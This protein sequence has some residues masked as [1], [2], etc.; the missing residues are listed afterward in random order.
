MKGGAFPECHLIQNL[1]IKFFVLNNRTHSHIVSRNKSIE[2]KI[3]QLYNN[4]LL[5]KETKI[6]IN[7][8]LANNF[9][10][11]HMDKKFQ[12]YIKF[13]HCGS[14]RIIKLISKQKDVL[15]YFQK[16][17]IKKH[18]LYSMSQQTNQKNKV[19]NKKKS[20]AI[21]KAISNWKNPRGFSIPLHHRNNALN[22]VKINLNQKFIYLSNVIDLLD[23]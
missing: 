12:K 10:N 19:E 1:F 6:M 17:K 22:E 8:N 3:K 9:G 4:R 16:D 13:T 2:Y 21:P 20:L 15:H 14:T 23:K 11:L 7:K 18:L 5:L